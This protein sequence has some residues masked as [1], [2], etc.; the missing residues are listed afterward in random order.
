MLGNELQGTAGLEDLKVASY[1][2][3]V[4]FLS[5]ESRMAKKKRLNLMIGIPGG[6]I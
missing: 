3:F 2:S 1:R 5:A 6:R 4:C